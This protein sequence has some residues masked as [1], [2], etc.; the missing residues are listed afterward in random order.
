MTVLIDPSGTSLSAEPAEIAPGRGDLNYSSSSFGGLLGGPVLTM[1][2]GRTVSYAKLFATQPWVASA[3]MRMLTW[4]VRV[5]LKVYRRTGDDSRE[6]LRPGDH[7]LADAIASPWDSGY[8]AALTQA[9]I[10]PLLVHGNSLLEV[11]D[12]ASDRFRFRAK[13]WRF[14][15][16][17]KAF[18]DSIDGWRFDI[19]DSRVAYERSADDVLHTAWWSPTGPLGISPL[20]QLGTT[21]RVEDAAQRYQQGIF[22]NA[23]RPP[24]AI[25]ASDEFLGLER[26][27]REVIMGNLRQD[28]GTIYVGP[29]N[30]GR[31][32]LLPPGLD[33]KPVGHTAVEAELIDQRRIAREEVAAVYQIP[34]PMIGI[35]DKATFSNI[36][37]QREMAY[38]DC[39][40]PPMVLI[41]QVLNAQ[42]V[43]D[44]LKEDEIY[45][46]FDFAGVLRGDRLKEINALRL[47]IGSAMLT[48]NEG[49]SKLN[50]PRSD[51]EG[52]DTFYLPTNN[53]APVG[54][55][56]ARSTPTDSSV[57]PGGDPDE[58]SAEAQKRELVLP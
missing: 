12:G 31:P 57:S 33:W 17:L 45:C 52:M 3:V 1:L 28:I 7:R 49:R 46:E 44:I 40:G 32:A 13:D 22:N 26:A 56:P 24:S 42:L 15:K 47:A 58:S 18:R 53:L 20:H 51:D 10:G 29:E 21:M 48:P 14:V 38:T 37:I 36:E 55:P 30:A 25:T 19:D 35:L 27:E 16:P 6:R 23:A 11:E 43:R 39:L 54:T 9:F 8:P 2:G 50:E 41:E 5:P 4:S 34:P